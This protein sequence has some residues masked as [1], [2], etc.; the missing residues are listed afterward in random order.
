MAKRILT[1]SLCIFFQSLLMAAAESPVSLQTETLQ[2]PGG[3]TVEFASRAYQPGEIILVTLK[4][5]P[6]FKSATIRFLGRDYHLERGE[7]GGAI[8][9]FIGLDLGLKPDRYPMEVSIEREDSR[10]DT[11]QKEIFVQ[12]KKFPVKKIWVKGEFVTPPPEVQERIQREAELLQAVYSIIIPNWLGHG[13]FVVPFSGKAAPNFGERRIYNNVPRS[14]HSG[15]DMAAPLGTPIQAS[16]SGKVVLASDLYFSGKTVIIDH[17]LGLFT[18]YCHFSKLIVK[19]GDWVNKGDVIG[20]AGSTGRS[21]GP[22][23]HWGVKV[24]ESRVDPFSLISL[25]L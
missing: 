14:L 1:F 4:E 8:F 21:T 19:R 20:K 15:V 7:N 13:E 12:P 11:Y 24:Y 6:S 2:T 22:H 17:G 3:V 9:I 25:P 18:F 5:N 16:N 23:L 10:K